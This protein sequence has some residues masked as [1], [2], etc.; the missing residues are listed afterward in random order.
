MKRLNSRQPDRQTERERERE[1]KIQ[2][3][4]MMTY[5]ITFT[6]FDFVVCLFAVLVRTKNQKSRL[7][8]TVQAFV[9]KRV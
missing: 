9:K 1:E 8:L 7:V 3:I 6:V 4:M 2:K 5:R